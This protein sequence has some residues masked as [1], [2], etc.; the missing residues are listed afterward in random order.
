MTQTRSPALA[1][2]AALMA[3]LAVGLPALAWQTP[4]PAP[5][6]MARIR[7]DVGTGVRD[8]STLTNVAV[9][10]GERIVFTASGRGY[11][12]LNSDPPAFLEGSRICCG[13]CPCRRAEAR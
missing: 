9:Q 5:A 13:C 8:V 10:P 4:L 7:V 1:R 2:T 11:S 3:C 6:E 12:R